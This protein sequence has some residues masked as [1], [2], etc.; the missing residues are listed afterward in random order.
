MATENENSN[1]GRPLIFG[2]VLFDH[3]PDGSRVLGGAPFNVAWH[4]QGFQANPLFVSR[5]GDDISGEEVLEKMAIWGM[6]TRGMQRD[7]SHPTG[8]VQV[9][10]IDGQ[11]SFDICPEQAYDYIQSAP[12][13]D[14]LVKEQFRLLYYGSLAARNAISQQT[15]QWL[16]ETTNIS[17]FVDINLR[18]PWWTSQGIH[19]LLNSARWIKLNSDEFNQITGVPSAA[20]RTE[21]AR[22]LL[23]R[24]GAEL[25][26]LTLG[27]EGAALISDGDGDGDE[28]YAAPSPVNHI[29]DT[30][31]AGDAFS[32]VTL[33]GLL[34]GWEHVRIL[35]NALDFAA[36]ICRVR[37]ATVIDRALYHDFLQRWENQHP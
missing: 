11:P 28:L 17:A 10:L 8:T 3:F 26:I 37:G 19:W 18:T 15:L 16:S 35:N 25:L 32:A 5:I 6:D 12:M 20:R 33:L 31:G 2:E 23:S 29:V 7:L 21:A 1:I 14:I 9:S 30:V 13:V 4:L 34:H 27:A 22:A 36:A 24:F